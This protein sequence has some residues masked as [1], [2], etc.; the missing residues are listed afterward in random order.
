LK[1]SWDQDFFTGYIPFAS[2]TFGSL[3]ALAVYLIPGFENPTIM[4]LLISIF[5]AIGIPIGSKFEKLYGKDPKQCT[6]D[7]F[8]GMWIS[9]LFVPKNAL[10]VGIAFIIWRLLDI[11]KPFPSRTV[12]K[13]KGGWGIMLDDIIA[14][15]YTLIIIQI[16][17][18]FIY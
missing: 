1:K 11:L 3:A 13:I 2:G 12:E 15:F 14:G 5:T 6:I 8:V 7:E 17:I 4:L 16:V 10:F 9:L 18:Y